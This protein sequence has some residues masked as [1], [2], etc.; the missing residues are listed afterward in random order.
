MDIQ[1]LTLVCW[2]V[3]PFTA[4]QF[5]VTTTFGNARQATTTS[6][7]TQ[8]ANLVSYKVSTICLIKSIQNTDLSIKHASLPST[9]DS[10]G[11]VEKLKSLKTHLLHSLFNLPTNNVLQW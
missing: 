11:T 4:K 9:M 5:A 8:Q 7:L 2:N 6:L 3:I 1:I 10:F